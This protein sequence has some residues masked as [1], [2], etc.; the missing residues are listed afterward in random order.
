M[1]LEYVIQNFDICYFF[2]IL[3][4]WKGKIW[5]ENEQKLHQLNFEVKGCEILIEK[6]WMK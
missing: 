5:I 3:V 2:S 1:T 4:S 6:F